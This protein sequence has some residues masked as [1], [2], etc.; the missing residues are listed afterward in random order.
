MDWWRLETRGEHLKWLDIFSGQ[1]LCYISGKIFRSFGIGKPKVISAR[2]AKLQVIRFYVMML[3]CA[4]AS[5]NIRIGSA[6]K[7][8]R[9]FGPKLEHPVLVSGDKK[10]I[11]IHL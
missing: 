11:A 6:P 4:Q 3:V 10:K 9:L 1:K 8:K 5:A 2:V 7:N